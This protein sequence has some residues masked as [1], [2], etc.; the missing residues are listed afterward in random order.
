MSGVL[1]VGA[2]DFGG[3]VAAWVLDSPES[4]NGLPLLGFLDDD[5]N[6]GISVGL[7]VPVV[8]T[9]SSYVHKEGNVLL[10]GISDPETKQNLAELLAATGATFGS[11]I[12]RTAV[13]AVGSVVGQGSVLCPGAVV[14]VG[15]TVGAFTTINLYG[16]IGHH[17][18]LGAY[19]SVMSHGDIMGHAVLGDRVL[20]G[21]RGGVLPRVKV[22][23]DSIVAAGSTAMRHVLPRTTV[24]GVPAKRLEVLK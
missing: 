16:T 2:G 19:C 18:T 24:I 13:I 17:A 23:S 6:C 1:I 9:V 8:G 22:G 15:A 5:P 21:S 11:F 14:S 7:D 10:M 3:E 4:I 12:H 20:V